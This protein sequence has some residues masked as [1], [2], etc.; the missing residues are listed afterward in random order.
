MFEEMTEEQILKEMLS[1]IPDDVFDV[2]PGS[3]I[4]D[5]LAPAASKFAQMYVDME[6]MIEIS[7]LDTTSGD[8]L[9]RKGWE[10]RLRR[11]FAEGSIR[12]FIFKGTPPE[13]GE[14]FFTNS[15]KLHWSLEKIRE[16]KVDEE[17]IALYYV[18]CEEA[19]VIGNTTLIG[20]SLIPVNNIEGL[21]EAKLGKVIIPGYEDEEDDVFRERIFNSIKGSE[22][23]SNKDQIIKWCKEVKG[24]GD[25]RV[26]SLWNGPCTVKA[27]LLNTE[28]LPPSDELIEEVQNYIDPINIIE[29]DDLLYTGESCECEDFLNTK[30]NC[31]CIEEYK[32]YYDCDCYEEKAEDLGGEQ[33]YVHGHGEGKASIG[34]IF[35]AVAA[36]PVYISVKAEL[37]VEDNF[38]N[39]YT[40][41]INNPDYDGENTDETTDSEELEVPEFITV[42]HKEVHQDLKKRLNE[43]IVNHFKEIAFVEDQ[44]KVQDIER[45]ILN[46]E[47]VRYFD[48]LEV[49]YE[50]EGGNKEKAEDSIDINE[51]QVAVFEGGEW[52]LS[53]DL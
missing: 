6:T 30:E 12:E 48:N 51:Y 31:N 4:Y 43:R 23:S 27:V 35:T 44:V 32:C 24:I 5:S 33:T 25:A 47:G 10:Y 9:D 8:F 20:E 1:N 40:E 42:Q 53:D 45:I 52:E 26:F 17:N 3:V 49:A 37:S 34:V 28:K 16:D 7:F 36:E 22:H 2:S 11:Y 21:E 15:D 18:R 39:E 50:D 46:I 38:I 19:G 41:T 13:I 14:R 29:K